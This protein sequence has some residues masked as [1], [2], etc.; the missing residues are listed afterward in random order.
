MKVTERRGS[1]TV[2]E[3]ALSRSVIGDRYEGFWEWGW[4]KGQGKN[5]FANDNRYEGMWE[6]NRQHGQGVWIFSDGVSYSGV[7]EHGVGQ[8]GVVWLFPDGV[9]K[10]HSGENIA[11]LRS[12]AYVYWTG[13]VPFPGMMQ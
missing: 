10:E 6:R 13:H 11:P 8:P 2:P 3:S 5:T 4:R 12:L 7:W 1:V 9:T